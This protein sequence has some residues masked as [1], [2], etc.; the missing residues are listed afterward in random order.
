MKVAVAGTFN[1]FHSGHKAMVDRALSF[2]GEVYIGITSD[3][4]ARNSRGFISP[5]YMRYNA[6]KGYV[7]SRGKACCLFKLED[8]YGPPEIMR[9]IDVLIV[10]EETLKNGKKVVERFSSNKKIELSVVKMVSKTDGSK[11][12]STDVMN[13]VCSRSG[14]MEA[15]DVA[16]GSL[17][18]VKVEAV[19][20]VM[21]RIYG[22][23]RIFAT[24]VSSGVSEQP[25]EEETE[26][27]ARNR[28]ESC[29]G[30]HTLGVGIEAGV[31]D[32][33]GCLYDIQYC[34]IIDRQKNV[35]IGMGPGFRYPGD[36]SRLVR[37]GMTVSE[38]I[39]KIYGEHDIGRSSGAIGV[40]SRGILDRK[41]L[42]KQSVIAAMIPRLCDGSLKL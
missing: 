41:E 30:S 14:D 16:V 23:V 1:V 22:D 29:I 2:D 7:E 3:E 40:L 4:M 15:I 27:G 35:T 18:F 37:S 10:S 9:S 19:R 8:V 28:A 33:Y 38:A 31:F 26:K 6:V 20:E 21:E 24:N 17:N 13:G 36:V 11:I 39:E 34:A 12:S 25:F 5:Y 32:R 42:T